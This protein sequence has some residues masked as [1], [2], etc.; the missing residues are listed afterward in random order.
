[1]HRQANKKHKQKTARILKGHKT[2]KH[3][4][5]T[6]QYWCVSSREFVNPKYAHPCVFSCNQMIQFRQQNI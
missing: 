4:N 5:I 2:N 6:A 1:M 3:R